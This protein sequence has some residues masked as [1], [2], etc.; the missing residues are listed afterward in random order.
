[1]NYGIDPRRRMLGPAQH[2]DDDDEVHPEDDAKD[3][4]VRVP[5]LRWAI[6]PRIRPQL[7]AYANPGPRPLSES[8]WAMDDYVT[9]RDLLL[10]HENELVDVRAAVP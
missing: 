5:Q 3:G 10:A 9:V 4:G 7:A 1:M 2:Y 6:P 8:N